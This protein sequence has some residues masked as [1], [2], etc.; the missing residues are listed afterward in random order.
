MANSGTWL[1]WPVVNSCHY[2]HLLAISFFFSTIKHEY[3]TCKF[4]DNCKN[5]K[6]FKL[7]K[8]RDLIFLGMDN[9][10][11]SLGIGALK[12]KLGF[13]PSVSKW[14][15]QSLPVNITPIFL[16]L[17]ISLPKLVKNHH[18]LSMR[19]GKVCSGG[20]WMVLE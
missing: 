1:F 9:L 7:L 3:S 8:I 12:G 17:R 11:F 5:S 4:E 2:F 13:R 15:F 6:A 18:C 14:F 20:W 19:C 16:V 10:L